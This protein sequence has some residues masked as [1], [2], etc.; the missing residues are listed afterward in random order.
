[1]A[2]A[3]ATAGLLAST[4]AWVEINAGR[5]PR[6]GLWAGFLAAQLGK[7]I[8]GG[9]WVGVG[10]IGF[11]IGAGLTAAQ[12]AGA[13]G[14]YALGLIV[15]AGLIAGVTAPL[16]ASPLIWAVVLVPALPLLQVRRWLD[17]VAVWGGRRLPA[18]LG[19]LELPGQASIIAC[20]AR[21]LV[22]QAAAAVAYWLLLTGAGAT[23]PPTTV[24][25][26]FGLAWLA[27]FL[28]IG[29]P[30]GLGA[31]EAALV[32]LLDAGTG[33]VVAA[34]VVHRLVQATGELA[35][36]AA[37]RRSVPAVSAASATSTVPP[38]WRSS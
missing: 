3:V 20:L 35:L 4:S 31:R 10:N 38:S 26:A 30:S 16:Q 18:R 25:C 8:P 27:G 21:L 36:L 11:G 32:L 29:F 5:A 17:R 13:L 22:A 7:Y 1:V 23:L 15:A 19:G 34:S 9:V 2:L 24:M 33:A 37:A 28:A 14:V 12:A 6:P